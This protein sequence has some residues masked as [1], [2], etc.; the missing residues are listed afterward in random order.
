MTRRIRTLSLG[1]A[2]VVLLAL[3]VG[4]SA[5]TPTHDGCPSSSDLISVAYLESI[6]DYGVPGRID[7]PANGGNGDGWVCEFP[8]PDAVSTAWG[9]PGFQIYMFFENNLPAAGRP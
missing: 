2:A 9:V 3:P 5:A 7:D 6:G 4:A 1:A 8:L